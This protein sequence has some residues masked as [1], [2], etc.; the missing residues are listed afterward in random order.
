[1]L[2]HGNFRELDV[3]TILNTLQQFGSRA[4]PGYMKPEGIVIYHVAGNVSFK[5]T[6]EK[7]DAHKSEAPK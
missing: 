7:D 1:V 5:A 3:P 6:I 4:V 2:W